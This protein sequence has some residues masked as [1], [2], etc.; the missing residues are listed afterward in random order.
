M[1]LES[2]C[3]SLGNKEKRYFQCSFKILKVM[4]FFVDKMLL[5]VSYSLLGR[6]KL[7]STLQSSIP[8][9]NK[10]KLSNN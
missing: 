6:D 2:G 8:K 1:I 7:F 4:L 9:Q 10:L 5:Q 3:W